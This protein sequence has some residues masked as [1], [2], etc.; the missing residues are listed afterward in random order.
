MSEKRNAR[1]VLVKEISAAPP[2]SIKFYIRPDA[3]VGL[4]FVCPCGCGHV[5]GVEFGPRGWKWDGN[6]ERPT[7]TPSIY[8]NRGGAGEW[9]GY[10]TN[11]EFVEC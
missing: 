9:H 7:V 10:L 6:R 3:V 8:F 5:G 2:G 1:A 11:G 4:H